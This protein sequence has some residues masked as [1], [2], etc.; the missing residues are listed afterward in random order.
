MNIKNK[1]LIILIILSAILFFFKLGNFSLYDAAETTYGEFIKQIHLTGDWI[2]MHYNGEIIFDKPP[3]YFWLASLATLL[4]GFGEFAIRFPAAIAGV[5]T[6]AA[7]FLLGKAFY[8]QRTG[9]LSA[10]IV[11]T[12]FQ[13]LVQSRIAEIDILLTLLITLAFLFFW[14]AYNSGKVYFYW[15]FY[16]VMAVGLLA[17]GII[18]I[19]IPA[20]AIFLFLLFKKE[21]GKIWEMHIPAGVL[22]T[23]LIGAPWYIAEGYLHGKE[24]L[25]F[26]IGFLFVSRFGGVVAGHP[27]PWFYYFLA[28]LLG[29]APWSHFLPYAF[30][31]TFRKWQESPALLSLCFIIPVFIVFSIAKTKL[32]N[33]VFPLFP[34]LAIMVGKVW[35]DFLGEEQ[36]KMR[37]GMSIAYVIFGIIVALLIIGFT[38]L[39]TSNYSVEYHELLPNLTL[40]GG[41][42]VGSAIFSFGLYI[43]Q[44]YK[45][46]FAIIP[47]M[48]FA[49]TFVLTT[50]TLPFVERFKGSKELGLKVSEVIKENEH[51]AAYNIGNRPSV[52]FYNSKPVV[53][54][55][56]EEQAKLFI[57]NKRGYLFTTAKELKEHGKV[58]AEKGELIVIK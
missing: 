44:Q 3:L 17:K 23:L 18:G 57:K 55:E 29:F 13:F 30:V 6:V 26:V 36:D 21:L 31:R 47:I 11:M 34:F 37:L 35:D 20:F 56:N 1:G 5:L 32:P 33:Y 7:T 46:S 45:L 27:G 12:T 16:T 43:F 15:L 19:A 2:T 10:I 58:F 8:N 42:L 53:F 40:L 51:I 22:I 39:G 38:I 14:H 52:V 49:I 9:F 28:L 50:Q 4:F 25:D 54:L 41:I 48:V 24:F